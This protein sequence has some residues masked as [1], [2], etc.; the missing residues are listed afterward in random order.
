MVESKRRPAGRPKRIPDLFTSE[1]KKIYLAKIPIPQP[2]F[3][4]PED[5]DAI[6]VTTFEEW[7]DAARQALREI[8]VAVRRYLS[9]YESSLRGVAQRTSVTMMLVSWPSS[10]R[11]LRSNK[12]SPQ[13]VLHRAQ[14][15]W[16]L[17]GR[18][19]A[20]PPLQCSAPLYSLEGDLR[21]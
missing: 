7:P 4:S 2:W 18:C 17:S 10:S 15:K 20:F 6:S 13:R 8:C 19:R 11:R 14:S 3:R 12:M 16:R 9:S 1:Q 21:S 5:Y